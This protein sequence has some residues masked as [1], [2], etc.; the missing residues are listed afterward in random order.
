MRTNEKTRIAKIPIKD[1]IGC[2]PAKGEP[3]KGRCIS[4]KPARMQAKN[5]NADLSMLFPPFNNN[6]MAIYVQLGEIVHEE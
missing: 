5:K 3:A 4:A 6:S 2:I 1:V